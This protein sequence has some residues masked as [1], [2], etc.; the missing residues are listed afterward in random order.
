MRLMLAVALLTSMGGVSMAEGNRIDIQRPD[1][2]ELAAPG[3]FDIG[4]RTLELVHADQPDV[5]GGGTYDRPLTV[6]VWYP[7]DLA[8]GT[9]GGDY[10]DVQMAN[11]DL[12]VTLHGQAVRDAAPLAADGPYPLVILSHGFPGNRFLISHFGENLASK[13]YV[14]ASIDHFESTYE[15][16]LG[17]ASTLAN[18]SPDQLFVLDEMARAGDFLAGMV[19][20]DNSAI[21]GYS[22]GGYGAVLSAGAGLAEAAGQMGMASPEALAGLMAGSDAYAAARDP[23]LKA[24]VA[25]A[26]WGGHLGLWD[27][28]G[29]AGI[30]IPLLMIGGSVDEVSDYENGIRRI[31]EGAVN[32]DRSMLTFQGAGHNAGAPMPPPEEATAGGPGSPFEHYADFVWDNARMNNIAQHFV[33]AF[34]DLHLKGDADKAAYLELDGGTWNAP[35]GDRTWKGFGERTTRGLVFEHLSAE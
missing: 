22:M 25:V 4:V 1:A 23:R 35:A 7:A 10:T 19:D 26:P 16:Q 15:N 34:L 5:L 6:E 2:P 8:G 32:A 31:Y 33:T 12:K 13:G 30:D 11:S 21:I 20:G 18:R 29:L 24:V 14:V 17:F 28:T 27:D 3:D 9:P